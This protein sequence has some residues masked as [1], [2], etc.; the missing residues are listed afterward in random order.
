MTCSTTTQLCAAG[1]RARCAAAVCIGL[2]TRVLAAAAL[3]A[4]CDSARADGPSALENVNRIVFLGDSIT[5][6][7]QYIDYVDAYLVTRYPDR[8]IEVVNIGLPSETASGLSEPG[9]AGGKFPR[10]CVH[11]RL[12]RLLPKAKADLI[13]ACYGMN[14]GIYYPLGEER[15]KAYQDGIRRLADAVTAAKARLLLLTPPTFDPVP[16]KGRTL[17]AGLDAYPKPYE[18][19]DGVLAKYGEWLLEQRA[20]GWAVGDI[21]GPMA[22]HLAERRKEKPDFLFAGDGVHANATGHWLMAQAVLGVWEVPAD[23][24]AAVID[25]AA[26]K[27]V[28]GKVTALAADAGGLRFSWLTRRP[29]PMDPA[30]DAESVK[31]ERIADRFNRHRLTVKGAP[32]AQY[33]LYEGQ[34]ALGTVTREQLAAGVDLLQ[35]PEL[36]T[37][38]GGPELLKLIRIRGRILCDAFLSDIG[39]QRPGMAKCL[40]LDEAM[41]QAAELDAQIRQMAAPVTLSLRLAA[42]GASGAAKP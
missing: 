11:E 25:A 31:I 34:T 14:D 30:W 8:K 18:R 5:Y 28:E 39:H 15:L 35:F 1:L 29:M 7:G 32:A 22:R 37:N 19:Y 9:H 40:P 13:V 20:K 6:G 33:Q 12:A 2:V 17:P 26:G 23:V 10:P 21:H 16:L 24:D 4:A 36:S 3:L 42:A 38:R 41:K 27:V